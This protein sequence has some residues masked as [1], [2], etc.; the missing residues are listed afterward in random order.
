MIREGT[1]DLVVATRRTRARRRCRTPLRHKDVPARQGRPLRGVSAAR[2]AACSRGRHRP[3]CSRCGTGCSLSSTRNCASHLLET[4][5]PAGAGRLRRGG[6]RR[7]AERRSERDCERVSQRAPTGQSQA[8][9]ISPRRQDDTFVRPRANSTQASCH[10]LPGGRHT[11]RSSRAE[12][13]AGVAADLLVGQILE[14]DRYRTTPVGE[15]LAPVRA[16]VATGDN[17]RFLR[18]WFEVNST[19]R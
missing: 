16:G 5:R 2:A 7:G 13:R 18:R 10:S 1:Y 19:R 4:L 11:L 8:W 15:F 17:D 3:R 6:L 14:L 9:H 12:G